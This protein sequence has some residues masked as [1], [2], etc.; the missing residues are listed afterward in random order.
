[1]IEFIR[2]EV[3]DNSRKVCVNP[4]SVEFIE[5]KDFYILIGLKSGNSVKVVGEIGEVY[6]RLLL[7]EKGLQNELD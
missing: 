3:N 2:Y 5:D 4:Q 6:S 7:E 1:M